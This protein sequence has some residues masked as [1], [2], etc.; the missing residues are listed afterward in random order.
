MLRARIRAVGVAC[1]AIVVALVVAAC[2][3]AAPADDAAAAPRTTDLSLPDVAPAATGAV[4]PVRAAAGDL[5]VVYFGY[6]ACPDVC[7][8]TM[9]DLGVALRALSPDVAA[10]VE[11]AMITIDPSGDTPEVLQGWLG[12]FFDRYR[13]YRPAD[14]PAVLASARV[15]GAQVEIDGEPG[16]PFYH[17]RHTG[18]LYAVDDA[19][20]ILH[21][22]PF[23]TEPDAISDDLRDLVD[24]LPATAA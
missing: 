23:G 18:G 22:W 4:T 1:A 17:V 11:P 5:L 21:I 8:T 14:V 9:A 24:D 20:R 7:P 19:G 6:T 12:H 10:R 13:A 3:G 15:F 16:T 2:G